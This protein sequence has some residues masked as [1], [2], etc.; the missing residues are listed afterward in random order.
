M[1]NTKLIYS[2]GLFISNIFV[3]YVFLMD[4]LKDNIMKYPYFEENATFPPYILFHKEGYEV[5]QNRGM[6][7]LLNLKITDK[8]VVEGRVVR[9]GI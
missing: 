2:D 1:C 8:G 6:I 9:G 4:L 3:L 5:L 7:F